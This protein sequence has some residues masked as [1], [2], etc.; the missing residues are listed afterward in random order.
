MKPKES[1]FTEVG[2]VIAIDNPNYDINKFPKGTKFKIYL[3][4]DR[5]R[6]KSWYSNIVTYTG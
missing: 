4:E 2:D 6:A 1:S 3:E 5:S